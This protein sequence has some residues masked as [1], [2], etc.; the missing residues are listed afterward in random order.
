MEAGITKFKTSTIAEAEMTA[1]AGGKDI[2]LAFQPVGPNIDRFID[3]IEAFPDTKFST[4]VDNLEIV[5][6][7][8]H[9]ARRLNNP[10]SLYID[11]DVGMHRSGMCAGPSAI[12][13]YQAIAQKSRH[14]SRFPRL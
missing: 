7:L 2:L 9:A 1:S 13:L 14:P 4:L 6:L 3:L 8:Q 12:K 11:L 5:D 10:I